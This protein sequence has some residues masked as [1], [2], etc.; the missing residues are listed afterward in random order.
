[1]RW[2]THEETHRLLLGAG[3]PK[4]KNANG[5]TIFSF[6]SSLNLLLVM[7]ALPQ[8]AVKIVQD[9]MEFTEIQIQLGVSGN[10]SF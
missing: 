10:L 3:N 1:M 4:L 8:W 2:Y 6:F 7:Y 5:K 9:V